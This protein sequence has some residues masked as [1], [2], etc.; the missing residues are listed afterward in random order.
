MLHH[1]RKYQRAIFLV[2]TVVIIMSFSFFGTYRTLDSTPNIWREQIAFK[3]INGD[4]VTR[5]DVEEMAH[6]LATDADDKIAIWRSIENT[7]FLNDGV[8]RNRF[9]Y[10]NGRG[11]VALAYTKS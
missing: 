11:L 5:L 6:F 10:R 8:I 2:I 4:E 9:L 3:A 7:N 1:F